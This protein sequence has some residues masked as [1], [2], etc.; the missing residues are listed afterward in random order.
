MAHLF[1]T[2]FEGWVRN[3]GHGY[4]PLQGGWDTGVGGLA[5][6]SQTVGSF[7]DKLQLRGQNLGRV[8]NSR[9]GCVNAMQLRCSEIK[10]S[11]L[12]LKT[13][14]KQLLSSLP[15]DIALPGSLLRTPVGKAGRK[16]SRIV[17]TITWV[18]FSTLEVVV[19]M[20]CPYCK[21]KQNSP[22]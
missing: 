1:A 14:P 17:S 13:R 3:A 19:C 9:S 16:N 7:I 20:P 18:E 15:L 21:V 2:E 8:F 10:L 12:M 11:N 22:T 6:S 5:P 4:H